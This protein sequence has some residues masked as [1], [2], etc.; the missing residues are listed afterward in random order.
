[1]KDSGLLKRYNELKLSI[2][3][4]EQYVKDTNLKIDRQENPELKQALDKY[5]GRLQQKQAERGSASSTNS[6]SPEQSR[7]VAAQ[8]LVDQISA[9]RIRG[10]H[11]PNV[12]NSALPDHFHLPI[13][14]APASPSERFSCDVSEIIG[15]SSD[16]EGRNTRNSRTRS[17][18]SRRQSQSFAKL[19]PKVMKK[20]E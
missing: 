8:I 12:V 10:Q 14:S 1:M 6:V 3:T 7:Q 13:S 18:R 11:M 20:I 17:S 9:Q 15:F 4:L 19:D 16:E 2:K 5:S